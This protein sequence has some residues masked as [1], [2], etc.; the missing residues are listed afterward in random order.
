MNASSKDNTN[1]F[2]KDAVNLDC[3]L[4]KNDTSS[5][6]SIAHIDVYSH[7]LQPDSRNIFY[8]T[9]IHLDHRIK[10][11]F[12]KAGTIDEIRLFIQKLVKNLMQIQKVKL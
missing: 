3:Q 1:K 5:I 9:D 4:K 11:R 12:P 7:K 8:I 2:W 6:E 10:R